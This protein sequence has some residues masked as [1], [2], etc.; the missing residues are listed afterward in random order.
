MSTQNNL[1]GFQ[2]V[3]D[4]DDDAEIKDFLL[5]D[6]ATSCH[7]V[8]RTRF[9]NVPTDGEVNTYSPVSQD[10]R[11]VSQRIRRRKGTLAMLRSALGLE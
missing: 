9:G 3:K 11:P 7:Q 4:W 8:I 2:K 6:R 10:L 1:A 5:E